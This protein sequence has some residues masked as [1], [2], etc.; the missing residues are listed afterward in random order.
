MSCDFAL[1]ELSDE[2]DVAR[3][4]RRFLRSSPTERAEL[5]QFLLRSLEERPEEA[6]RTEWLALAEKRMAEVRRGHSPW[7]RC[8]L[9]AR[10]GHGTAAH[11]G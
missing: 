5:V 7:S 1:E 9:S 3:P 6:T 11:S 4:Q 10:L 2:S 8:R